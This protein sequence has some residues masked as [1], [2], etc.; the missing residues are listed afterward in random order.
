[1]TRDELAAY[2]FSALGDQVDAVVVGHDTGF[3]FRKL[4]LATVLLQRNPQA[5]LVATNMDAFDLVGADGRH[6]P[7]NGSLV[8][9]VRT[10][11]SCGCGQPMGQG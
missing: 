11:V 2:D 8:R 4:C 5:L 3:N 7:G 6:I 10:M 9:S 1:M